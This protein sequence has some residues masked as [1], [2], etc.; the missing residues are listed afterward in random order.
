MSRKWSV[1]FCSY[2]ILIVGCAGL[3]EDDFIWSGLRNLGSN[4]NSSGKDEHPTFT[5]DGKTMYFASIREEGKGGYDIYASRFERGKWTR[6]ELLP[7]PI[8][9]DRDEFDVFVTLD[10]WK[11][12]RKPL[13]IEIEP[14]YRI[15]SAT[16]AQLGQS[17]CTNLGN[18]EVQRPRKPG[19]DD[20]EYGVLLST[21]DDLGKQR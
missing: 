15:S 21:T 16:F 20:R 1:Y 7:S 3:Q 6:A 19:G 14:V 5:E 2:V 9:T 17:Q 18:C 12:D 10:L 4:I 8:N 11:I 13:E